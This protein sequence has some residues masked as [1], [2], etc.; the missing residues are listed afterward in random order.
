MKRSN[1]DRTATERSRARRARAAAR[2]DIALDERHVTALD[3]ARKT[4]EAGR[5][6]ESRADCVRRLIATALPRST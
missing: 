3:N 6:I 1:Y 2:L 4:D 5:V